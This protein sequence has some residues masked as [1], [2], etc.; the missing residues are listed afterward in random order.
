MKFSLPPAHRLARINYVPRTAAF[1][2]TF[3]ALCALFAE[4][5]F[6]AWELVFAVLSFLVYP[7]LVYLHA[8]TARDSK[9]AELNNLYLDAILMGTWVAQ[10]HFALSPTV[11]ILIA[12]TLNN[13]ANGGVRR[14]FWGSVCFAGAAAL[15]GAAFGYRF[16]LSTG[17]LVRGISILGIFAYVSWVGTILFVQNKVLARMHHRL[18]D[19]ESQFNF[20]AEN[21][22]D[23]V[24]VLDRQGRILYAS[25]SHSRHF[26]PSLVGTG[27]LWLGLV[28]PDD[29]ERAREFLDTLGTTQTRQRTR[30]RMVPGEGSLRLVECHGNP[31]IDH[32]GNMTA[33]VVVTQR[34]TFDVVSTGQGPRDPARTA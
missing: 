31:V 3:L 21:P 23:A 27:S 14:L 16:D 17:A 29:R 18:K 6:T 22:G 24:S 13:A 9:Q 28:H 10:I 1:A 15:W 33:I 4:R 19:S 2:L 8:R 5:G 11:V 26:D 30:L 20:V 12:I 32:H 34:S 25:S 7:H